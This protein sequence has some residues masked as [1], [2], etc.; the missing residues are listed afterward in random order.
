MNWIQYISNTLFNDPNFV[1]FEHTWMLYSFVIL[2]FAVLLFV[3]KHYQ[4]RKKINKFASSH[5]IKSLL[6]NLSRNRAILRFIIWTAGFSFLII[7]AANLQFG[8]KKQTLK[9]AGIN[10]I[11]CLDVSKSMMAEDIKPFRLKRAK[12]A[13]SKIINSLGSDRIGIVVFAGDAYLQLPLTSDH[14]AAK[15][16][17]DNISTDLIPVQGTNI[18]NAL[19]LAIESFPEGS[20]TNKAVVIISDGEDHDG[21]A[22]ELAESA[23]EENI[24]V[25]TIGLGSLIG[26]TIPEF[27]NG[28]KAGIKKDRNGSAIITRLNEPALQAIAKAGNGKYVHGTN[29]TLGLGE[30]LA[31][32]GGIKKTEYDTKEFTS[33]N[34][35]YQ[36]FLGIGLLLI[37]IEFLIIRKKGKWLNS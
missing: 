5:L 9:K 26:S 3:F 6:P 8:D 24:K 27:R 20:P 16:Y 21:K 28:K 35:K 37:L 1:R 18:A 33:Y 31:D 23:T 14:S 4:Q 11:I 13:I 36:Y 2:L 32:I 30:M 17:L 15:M 29:A 25:Y 19:E 7:G 22:I 34:S 10:L 12:L